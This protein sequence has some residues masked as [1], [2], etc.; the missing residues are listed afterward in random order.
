MKNSQLVRVT[1][2]TQVVSE[3]KLVVTDCQSYVFTNNGNTRVLLNFSSRLDPGG[4]FA[5][6]P[7]A[8][9]VIATDV[10]QVAFID[11]PNFDYTST[12]REN[13]VEMTRTIIDDC[14]FI[15]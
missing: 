8:L 14:N 11:L 15:K 13:R 4:T 2:Q 5:F 1:N 6:A 12:P 3:N 7:P 10:F 9:N